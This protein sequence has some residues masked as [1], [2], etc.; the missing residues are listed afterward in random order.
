ME[1]RNDCV[2]VGK[3]IIGSMVTPEGKIG[4]IDIPDQSRLGKLRNVMKVR[5]VGPDVELNVYDVDGKS[6]KLAAGDLVYVSSVITI[7]GTI[8]LNW[9][10]P[11]NIIGLKTDSLPEFN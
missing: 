10:T 2:A 3:V 5:S 4:S 7:P 8:D 9:T 6:R 11:E 1:E